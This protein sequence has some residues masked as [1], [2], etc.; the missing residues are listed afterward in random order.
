MVTFTQSCS[1]PAS[2]GF[3]SLHLV[4][5]LAVFKLFSRSSMVTSS[6]LRKSIPSVNIPSR[7]HS[8]LVKPDSE[9]DSRGRS[10]VQGRGSSSY[11]LRDILLEGS[12]DGFNMSSSRWNSTFCTSAA[13]GVDGS[14][15]VVRFEKKHQ[16]YELNLYGNRLKRMSTM[17]PFPRFHNPGRLCP[18]LWH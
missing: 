5:M 1:V 11:R 3:A 17:Q 16:W 7:S 10:T 14:A 8:K 12:S 6:P 15:Y 2:S 18:E 13:F 9:K 4:T